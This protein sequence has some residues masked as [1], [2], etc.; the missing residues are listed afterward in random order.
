MI[1]KRPT[2]LIVD[3]DP[4]N[5]HLLIEI[6][7]E[8]YHIEVACDG[9]AALEVVSATPYPGLV[10]VNV[11][12]PRLNGY[13]VCRRLKGNPGT[14]LIPIIL[15]SDYSESSAE[16]KGFEVGAVDFITKPFSPPIVRARVRTHLTL[17]RLLSD[18]RELSF[19]TSEQLVH[20]TYAHH[21]TKEIHTQVYQSKTAV[22]RLLETALQPLSLQVQL[23]AILDIVCDV[24]FLKM[25]G[26]GAIFLI[27]P[28]GDLAMMAH[29]NMDEQFPH[30]CAKLPQSNCLCRQA[31]SA[32]KIIFT[33]HVRDFTCL[34]GPSYGHCAI[35]LLEKERLLGV[36]TFYL[37][38]GYQLR[39]EELQLVEE[40]GRV[41]SEL[42]SR[43][44]ME[45]IIQVREFELKDTQEDI[46]R[47][48]GVAAEYRDTETGFHA[49]RVGQYT[50][51][52]A[53]EI[54]L[55]EEEQDLLRLAATMHDV[56]K[57]G[58]PDSILLNPGTLTASE[59]EII[60]THTTIGAKILVGSSHIVATARTIALTHHERWDGSGYPYS[61]VGKNIPL[62]G[63]LCAVADVFD[64][65]TIERPYKPVWS[66]DRTFSL[67]KEQSGQHFDPE[68]VDAFVRCYPD[69]LDIKNT[70]RDDVTDSNVFTLLRPL[71][72]D[73]F[74]NPLWK[75]DYLI[76]VDL[77]DEHHRYLFKLMYYLE[78]ALTDRQD[79]LKICVALKDME[80]Y[81]LIH[82]S[83]EE[84]L[85][86]KYGDPDYAAHRVAHQVF[87]E[88]I[89]EFWAMMRS[90]PLLVQ[91]NVVSFLADWLV[92]HIVEVDARSL[93]HH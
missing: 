72:I 7:E 69:I 15:L 56:G 10:L 50:A 52:I 13:E 73:T 76:G 38:D 66:T 29:K 67:I 80:N 71:N 40:M 74:D 93:H 37:T 70:Y 19:L 92:K 41:V 33:S 28:N 64:A 77:I 58:I 39:P 27:Q 18:T 82:F 54:G 35:P 2:I 81:A 90:S 9:I 62:Y 4:N 14:E 20:E 42:V 45:A 36:L 60:K 68:L 49:I 85:M 32:R 44:L 75:D 87:F 48:L 12:M 78:H 43:R 21:H 55:S 3:N 1:H 23:Q 65:L 53:A 91:N 63:R 25:D 47:K 84:G 59:F 31:V 61:L 5:V 30:C 22:I 8:D 46:V 26:W 83:A 57:I 24:S 6:L 51:R 79:I 17:N 34:G 89:Q 86:R 16:V 88:K 11:V